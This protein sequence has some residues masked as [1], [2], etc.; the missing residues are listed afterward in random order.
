[1]RRNSLC[2]RVS[3]SEAEE[4]MQEAAAGGR[5]ESCKI[6][7]A[8]E[9]EIGLLLYRVKTGPAEIRRT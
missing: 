3:L 7:E 8:L 5:L 2:N 9:R 4:L 1:M 6:A